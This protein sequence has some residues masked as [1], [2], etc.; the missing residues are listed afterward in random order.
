MNRAISKISGIFKK[1]TELQKA[2]TECR[3]AAREG[4]ETASDNLDGIKEDIDEIATDLKQ[5]LT[6]LSNGKIRTTDIEK[7]T[8]KQLQQVVSELYSLHE[9]SYASLKEKRVQLDKFSIAL[10][11]R[12]MTGKST[13]MEVLTNGDGASIGKGAQRTTR[14]V[15][16]L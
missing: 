12:T 3:Y 10:F 9:R 7:Q 1:K 2:L 8:Q 14:D 11:G 6:R 4:Y 13:L 15:R 5:H 16:R